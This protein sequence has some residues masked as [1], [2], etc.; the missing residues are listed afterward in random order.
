[1]KVRLK[2]EVSQRKEQKRNSATK[3]KEVE[4]LGAMSRKEASHLT[5]PNVS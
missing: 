2:V 3:I 4:G 1:M 5:Y